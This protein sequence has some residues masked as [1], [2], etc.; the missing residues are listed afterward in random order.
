MQTKSIF[1]SKTVA[2]QVITAAAAFVPAVQAIVSAHP[3]ETLLILG[4]L[5]TALRWITK[6][7]VAL[8]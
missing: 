4:L 6:D 1:T 3:A 7:K 2:V 8:F 5:N